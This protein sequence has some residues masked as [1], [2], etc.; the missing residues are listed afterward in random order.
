MQRLLMMILVGVRL[1]TFDRVP[2]S[3]TPLSVT[4]YDMIMHEYGVQSVWNVFVCRTCR[5]TLP[6]QGKGHC[7]IRPCRG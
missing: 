3:S 5:L 7:L 2:V 4:Q 1:I 6:V